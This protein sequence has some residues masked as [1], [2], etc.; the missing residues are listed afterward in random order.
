MRVVWCRLEEVR[1][2]ILGPE[3]PPN[4]VAATKGRASVE[5]QKVFQPAACPQPWTLAT[6]SRLSHLPRPMFSLHSLRQ[7]Q[8]L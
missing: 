5:L 8:Q 2:A 3:G 6:S 1:R 4:L 7:M